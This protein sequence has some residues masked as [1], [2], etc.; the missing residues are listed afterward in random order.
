MN[1]QTLALSGVKVLLAEDNPT[2]QM[3]AIQMLECLGAVVTLAVDGAEALGIV[4]RE[5]FDVMLVDIEMPRVSGLEVIKAL[6]ASNG[7]LSEMPLI[8][9]TAY[10]MREHKMAIDEAGADGVIAKPI[11]SI[12]QFGDDII[13]HMNKR[14]AAPKREAITAPA[15]CTVTG[16]ANIE[17]GIYDALEQAIG[18]AQMLELLEKVKFDIEDSQKTLERSLNTMTFKGIRSSTHVMIS[19]AGAIGAVGLQQMAND[20]N[21]AANSNNEAAVR[22]GGPE[23]LAEISRVLVF[24]NESMKR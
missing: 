24:V 14:G 9:L 23:I 8:A 1:D 4:Q 10:V 7:K 2:N 22:E 20:M 11:L 3:V 18:K 16:K 12:E 5:E 17:Q 6:R 13:H 21:F 15:D 19:V